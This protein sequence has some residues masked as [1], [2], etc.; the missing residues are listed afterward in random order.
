MGA[1]LQLGVRLTRAGG[2]L[3]I[4]SVVIGCALAVALLA[5]AW[6][7]PDAMFPPLADPTEVDPQRGP[8]SSLL[9][10]ITAP[11]IALL[12][13]VGRMS[14]EVRDRRLAS[15]VMLGVSRRRVLVVAAVENVSPALVGSVAGIGAFA[16]LRALVTVAAGEVMVNPIAFGP[17]LGVVVMGVVLLSTLLAVA[18]I[19]RLSGMPSSASEATPLAPSLWRL[20]PV[21][22]AVVLLAAVFATPP[23]EVTT[24]TALALY[25]AAVAAAFSVALVTPL[26]IAAVARLLVRTPAVSPMLAGRFVQTQGAAI[27]RRVTALGVTTFV[28]VSAA[29]YLGL[30]E[31]DPVTAAYVHQVERGPQEIWIN[32]SD[33]QAPLDPNLVDRLDDVAGVQGVWPMW[34]L[35]PSQC[36]VDAH[37]EGSCPRL[38]VGTCDDLALLAS[39]S[40][41]SDGEAAWI[42]RT[43]VP[44]TLDPSWFT[45]PANY[46]SPVGLTVGETGDSIALTVSGSIT[47]DVEATMQRWPGPTPYDLFVPIS[48]AQ[49]HDAVEST[50]L[51][52]VADAGSAVRT[53]V[54]E[55]AES[56]GAWAFVPAIPD[57][58]RIVTLRTV[59]WSVAAASITVALLVFTLMS[60]DRARTQ[61]RARARLVAV[62]VP[63]RVLRRAQGLSNGTPLAV[64]VLLALGLGWASV[65]ALIH[66]ADSTGLPIDWPLLAATSAVIVL[67]AALVSLVT[68]PLTRAAIRADDLRQE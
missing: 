65:A 33:S 18:P 31:S 9:A 7:L 8:V 41:C 64:A 49:E 34:T 61:R 38:F 24:R 20:V 58:Q 19:R 4:G 10:L 12:L 43:A 14:S 54:L 46:G 27:S 44:P 2:G 26:V 3:R 6:E 42:E 21:P 13:A 62:G 53:E 56:T 16:V 47:Q 25:G 57:Y 63:A 35:W 37:G 32:S 30:Y 50:R 22:I 68:L 28:V 66:T 17:R 59:V 36:T 60:I 23:D 1:L 48:V 5:L 15:L 51:N 67:A 45:D 55:L 52:V 40:G 11:V 29:G 39:V